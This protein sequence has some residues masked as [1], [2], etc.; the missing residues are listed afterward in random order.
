MSAGDVERDGIDP[1]TETG[2]FHALQRGIALE[3]AGLVPNVSQWHR[4]LG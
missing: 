1:L 4:F 2:H 3:I